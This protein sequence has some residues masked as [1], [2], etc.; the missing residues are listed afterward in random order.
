MRSM[1][2]D[3]ISSW[4]VGQFVLLQLLLF[5]CI[6]GLFI[7]PVL[8]LVAGWMAFPC[9]INCAVNVIKEFYP[10]ETQAA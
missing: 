6:V 4:F 9:L 1:T 2:P 3:Q 10:D 7:G 8:T 5:A